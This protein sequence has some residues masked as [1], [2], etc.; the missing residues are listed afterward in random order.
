MS[1]TLPFSIALVALSLSYGAAY[2]QEIDPGRIRRMTVTSEPAAHPQAKA[3]FPSNVKLIGGGALVD[4]VEP[5]NLLTGS[6]PEGNCWVALS[7]DHKA[8]SPATIK[9]FA[10]GIFDPNNEFQV[11]TRKRDSARTNHPAVVV[12]LDA[13]FAM[14]GGGGRTN[15]SGAGSL[16]IASFPQTA[17]RWEVRAKDHQIANPA[18]VTAFVIGIRRQGGGRISSRIDEG[19]SIVTAHPQTKAVLNS[20]FVLTGGGARANWA[21][22][23]PGN[24]LTSSFPT[25]SNDWMARSKDH[26][27]SS[28]AS[29]TTFAIGI[30]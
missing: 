23:Q 27:V 7:K 1:R 3:C 25:A 20:D 30:R 19:T 24:M 17:T 29:I 11:I 21:H 15:F 6:F 13:G 2:S 10:I 12:D 26:F 8:S 4:P 18:T 22:P 9:A 5:G 16:L 28:P 14:T